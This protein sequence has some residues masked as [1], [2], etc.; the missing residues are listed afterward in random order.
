MAVTLTRPAG[1]SF[2]I[3]NKKVRV[4][5]VAFSGSYATGGEAITATQLGM[6]RIIGILAGTVT[7]A[8]GQTTLWSPHFDSANSKVKLFGA[9]TGATGITEHAAAAYASNTAG[10]LTFI[11]E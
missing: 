3:G 4:V 8:A 6:R 11:G 9:G 7:E 10:R 1:G 5:D 2:N